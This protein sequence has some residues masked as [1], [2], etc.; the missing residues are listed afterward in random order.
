MSPIITNVLTTNETKKNLHKRNHYH[1]HLQIVYRYISFIVYPHPN[2]MSSVSCCIV[3]CVFSAFSR[4][5]RQ[6]ILSDDGDGICLGTMHHATLFDR[7]PHQFVMILM[8]DAL[9]YSH[10]RMFGLQQI[11]KHFAGLVVYVVGVHRCGEDVNPICVQFWLIISGCIRDGRSV[12]VFS[13]FLLH[14][15]CMSHWNFAKYRVERFLV[16]GL[17]NE[18]FI[19]LQNSLNKPQ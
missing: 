2:R 4:N 14:K 8:I 12:C 6:R 10:D 9:T 3:N 11:G 16:M 17:R 15:F 5:C 13:G 1:R 7:Q 19:G 18:Y